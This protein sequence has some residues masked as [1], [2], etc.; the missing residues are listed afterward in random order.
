MLVLTRATGTVEHRCITDLPD[1]LRPGDLA[2]FN[3]TRVIPARLFS[4][5]GTVEL[6]LLEETAPSVWR[7]L[8]KPGRRLPVG[9][10]FDVAGQTALV[11]AIEPDGTR[12][13][14]FEGPVDLDTHGEL[15]LPPYFDRR[16]EALDAERYQTVFASK[17]GAVAA[18]T[19]GL[20]F[21]EEMLR[22]VQHTFVT[23][24]VG[25]GTFRPVQVDQIAQH[26][27]HSERFAVTQD[28]A[29][30]I[31][32]A[33]RVLAVGTTTVRVLESLGRPVRAGEGT[34]DIF[35]RPPRK[36]T[37]VDMLLTNFHLPKSTLLMLV[38]AMAGR[39]AVL[40]AYAEAMQHGYRFF[41]YGDCMLII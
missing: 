36:L 12:H 23:L 24:H 33:N 31:N 2:V 25:V 22:R 39:E 20:H 41:S 38:S 21:T 29:A 3:D 18:P 26:V 34:T 35:I 13:L 30:A 16:A 9:R 8:V 27:M 6:L 28:A 10:T 5:D 19:A 37:S 14:R 1:Y 4:S 11:T 32:S 7:A 17:P 15:P 40:A